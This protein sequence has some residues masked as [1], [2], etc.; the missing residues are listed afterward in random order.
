MVRL[1]DMGRDVWELPDYRVADS[2]NSPA[3]R[4]RLLESVV[5][6]YPGSDAS[7]LSDTGQV[8]RNMQKSYVDHRGYSLGYNFVV[9]PAGVLWEARGLTFS[10]AAN[11]GANSSSVSVQLLV[12]GQDAATDAQV[13]RVRRFVRDVR[14]W[15]GKDLSVVPH[16]SVSATQCPGEGIMSQL[17][18]GLF[19][20]VDV[21]E[22]EFDMKV[23]SPVR[24]Y[25]S[26]KDGGVFSA[27]E[28]RTVDVGDCAAA[29]VNVTVVPQGEEGFVTVWGS[30]A[31]PDVSNV[32]YRDHVVCNTSWVPVV[33]GSIQ[34]FC[35]E[36]ADVIVDLQ[37]VDG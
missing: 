11:R 27:R 1:H 15:C 28:V 6:H 16:R 14:G 25:D 31:M 36:K 7:V 20:P 12:R 9:D 8:L 37:A 3:V 29:F 23:V 34:V 2:T 18:A 13:E 30:G 17:D 33:D 35:W 21:V 26:R 10:N 19:E 32:N 22:V 24:V 4:P 5:I